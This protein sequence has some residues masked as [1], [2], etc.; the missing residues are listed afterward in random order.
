MLSQ[1]SNASQCWLAAIIYRIWSASRQS[2]GMSGY[3]LRLTIRI[4]A[5]SGFIYTVTNIAT[6]I[7]LVVSS[8]PVYNE[9]A[10]IVSEVF[11]AINYPVAGIAFNLI[12]IR[13]AQQRASSDVVESQESVSSARFRGLS[14][15]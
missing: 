10:I 8:E 12:L 11:S 6:L 4:I 9:I 15:A 14:K 7:S 1:P 2:T 5:E 3:N 13:V